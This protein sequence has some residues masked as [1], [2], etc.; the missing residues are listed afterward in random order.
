VGLA[1][2]GELTVLV[3]SG[4]TISI[5]WRPRDRS[6]KRQSDPYAR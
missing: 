1:L 3:T 5:R 6:R 4:I 2:D